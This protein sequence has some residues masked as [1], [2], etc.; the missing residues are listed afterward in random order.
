MFK[1]MTVKS[2]L[3]VAFV[4]VTLI[5]C[6][7][8]AVAAVMLNSSDQKYSG[9]LTNYGL[10][11]GDVGK[12]LFSLSDSRT[13]L[14][15][16]ALTTDA[17]TVSEAS[18][19]IKQDF[20][21]VDNSIEAL[22]PTL[23][24]EGKTY[25]AT[26]EDAYTEYKAALSDVVD[27][28]GSV[29]LLSGK[30]ATIAV[31]TEDTYVAATQALTSLLDSKDA[32]GTELSSSLTRSARISLFAVI[33]LIVISIVLCFIMATALTKSIVR[34]LKACADRMTLLSHGDLQTPVPEAVGNDEV[35][36]M[37]KCTQIIVGALS[38]I[39][40]DLES[41]LNA[42]SKGDF[43]VESSCRELYIG[44]FEPLVFSIEGICSRLSET[45]TQIGEASAQVDAG[46]DQVSSG[47][48]ALSQGATEQASSVQE[49][50]AT[51]NDIS[52]NVS[53][54][55]QNAHN[56]NELVTKVGSD[57][58]ESNHK[59][60]EM[61]NAM[62]QIGDASSQIGKII[63]TIEDIAFQTNILA[64][65]A[66]VEAARAGSAGKGFAVVADEVRN[67]AGKSQDAAKNTTALIENA[68]SAVENGTMIADTTATAMDKVVGDAQEVVSIVNSISGSSRE[69]ADSIAQITQGID[70]ISS[71][72][73]TNSATAEE[74]AAASEELS[75]QAHLLKEL[76]SNFKISKSSGT[77]LSFQ[78]QATPAPAPPAAP[79]T[80]TPVYSASA[81][82]NA[83]INTSND[84][85]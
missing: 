28:A 75:G 19:A 16:M 13:E 35:S 25:L 57:L 43:T 64:L 62:T 77:A 68:I 11:Q 6:I 52:N 74:S 9:A 79:K 50:A 63:K 81:S 29:S 65:N 82:A 78:K 32:L 70:Q 38:Q 22:K 23:N 8:G 56:A 34:P 47:A 24:A 67:L 46:A 45:M 21:D 14:Q 4:I 15:R 85:Y 5:A 48:Q 84:K 18:S 39:V 33:G 61:T 71:V 7:S 41:L 53:T 59:M 55:A 2:R 80:V 26:F 36:G 37:V 69:Q 66:A 17:S 40:S 49:L 58:M 54:N 31:S 76:L 1:K 60:S 44:D 51:I 42:M 27:N 83:P 30:A 72:V 3:I 73:Q 12:A 20:S 10:A